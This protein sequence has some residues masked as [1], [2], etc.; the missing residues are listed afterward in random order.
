MV[1]VRPLAAVVLLLAGLHTHLHGTSFDDTGIALAAAASWVGVPGPGEPVLIA[2]G[3]YASRGRVDIGEVLLVAWLGATVGGV[4]GWQLG[5]RG[6]RA[7]WSAPGP[8]RR[9][10]LAAM[11][12]G[13]RFYERHALLGVYLA[14]SWVAGIHDMPAARFLPMNALCA[15]AWALLVG[16]GA[17]LAGPSIAD[18]VGD[19]GLAG[20]VVLGA[21]LLA[22]IVGALLRRR[23]QSREGS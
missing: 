4:A 20:A 10:R 13:E 18:V 12:R 19:L 23:A 8:F 1:V 5:R 7:L 17:Y 9:L 21:L 6:G 14:P 2:A 16:G 3:I 11:M 22:G 15:A